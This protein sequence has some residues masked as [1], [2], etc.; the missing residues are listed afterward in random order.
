ME[1]HICVN[2]QSICVRISLDELLCLKEAHS[3][4]EPKVLPLGLGQAP[5][6]SLQELLRD[7]AR[8][9]GRPCVVNTERIHDIL[10]SLQAT[11]KNLGL[12]ADHEN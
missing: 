8:I 4:V 9:V 11:F 7:L 3:S 2:Q 10:N 1:D 6:V 12:V 5:F